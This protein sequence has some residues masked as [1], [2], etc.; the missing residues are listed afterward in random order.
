VSVRVRPWQKFSFRV[1]DLFP[2]FTVYIL[3]AAKNA[4][5]IN[6]QNLLIKSFRKSRPAARAPIKGSFFSLSHLPNL[7]TSIFSLRGKKFSFLLL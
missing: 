1:S 2:E 6:K 3:I 5:K 4:K 7:P